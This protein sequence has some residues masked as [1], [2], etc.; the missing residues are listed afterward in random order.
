MKYCCVN[1]TAPTKDDALRIAKELVNKKLVACCN[2]V[3]NICSVYV[4]DGELHNDEE[5][6]MIMKTKL[7]L[8]KKVRTEIKKLHKYE[9]PEIIAIPIEAVNEDYAKFIDEQTC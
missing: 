8:F 3:P 5:V 9:T 1:C 7:E 6:L 4:W 2:I